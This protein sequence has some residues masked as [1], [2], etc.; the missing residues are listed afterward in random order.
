MAIILTD[1]GATRILTRYFKGTAKTNSLALAHADNF[2]LK[3]YINNQTPSDTDTLASYTQ[4]TEN[5]GGY[6]SKEL[7]AAN[8]TVSTVSNIAQVAYAQQQFVFSAGLTAGATI[9]GYFIVDS[10]NI[11]IYAE[12]ASQPFTPV[13]AGDAVL[14]TPIFQLSKGTPT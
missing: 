14:L 9:Y 11:L 12:R 6:A 7:I 13:E 4:V 5:D 8:F 10:D 1:Q 3:L 2:L